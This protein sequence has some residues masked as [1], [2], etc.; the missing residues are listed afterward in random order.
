MR[1]VARGRIRSG[2]GRQSS[3]RCCAYKYSREPRRRGEIAGIGV[4]RHR[5][6]GVLVCDGDTVAHGRTGIAKPSH[7]P[8]AGGAPLAIPVSA[9]HPTRASARASHRPRR[10]ALTR[11]RSWP[12]HFTS[13]RARRMLTRRRCASAFRRL[14]LRGYADRRCPRRR[15]ACRS[16]RSNI[17]TAM[18]NRTTLRAD[19]RALRVESLR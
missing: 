8:D 19:S 15:H 16:C 4:T 6:P 7:C 14:T 11:T 12:P 2:E 18:R 13:H 1:A 9:I 10:R 5:S 3:G 17:R